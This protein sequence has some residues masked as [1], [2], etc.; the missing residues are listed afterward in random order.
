M[1]I[2]GADRQLERGPS[3]VGEIRDF[4][5]HMHFPTEVPRKQEDS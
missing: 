4:L 3:V 5:T 2:A 1:R